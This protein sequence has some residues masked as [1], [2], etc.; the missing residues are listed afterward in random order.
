MC[1]HVDMPATEE[2]VAVLRKAVR[3][4]NA[5]KKRYDDTL[6]AL[7]V[8]MADAIRSG[9]R[10]GDVVEETGYTREHVR[11]LVGKVEDERAACTVAD[12]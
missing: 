10:Q 12:S 6:D 8:A 11:R 7:A 2:A 3:A 9:M 4:K 5:A 1:E